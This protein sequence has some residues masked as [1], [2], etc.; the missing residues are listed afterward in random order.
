[1][2]ETSE[3]L[4]PD[5]EPQLERENAE[6][7]DAGSR[8]GLDSEGA[9]AGTVAASSKTRFGSVFWKSTDAQLGGGG[10]SLSS[11]AIDPGRRSAA[12]GTCRD[13]SEK[14]VNPMWSTVVGVVLLVAVA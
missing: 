11:F 3:R 8:P 13:V 14:C 4:P 10:S 5:E 2:R 9:C 12:A 1:M 6:D 7:R